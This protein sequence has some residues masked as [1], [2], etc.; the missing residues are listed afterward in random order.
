MQPD[1]RL[2]PEGLDAAAVRAAMLAADLEVLARHAGQ[3][4]VLDDLPEALAAARTILGEAAV[5]LRRT[6][7]GLGDADRAAARGFADPPR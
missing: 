5:V 3:S 2:D 4:L 6:A 7:V 1:L